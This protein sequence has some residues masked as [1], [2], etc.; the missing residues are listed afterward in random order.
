[1]RDNGGLRVPDSDTDAYEIS[2]SAEP[3]KLECSSPSRVDETDGL[4]RWFLRF[5]AEGR[6]DSL[7]LFPR[8]SS[9]IAVAE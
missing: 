2:R 3:N 4:R 9:S 7:N 1:M 8:S 6:R 5:V